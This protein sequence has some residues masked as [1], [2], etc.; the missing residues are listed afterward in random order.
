MEIFHIY[1]R[2]LG[3]RPIHVTIPKRYAYFWEI[4]S[5]VSKFHKIDSLDCIDPR[6]STFDL[7]KKFSKQIY[8][9]L[10]ILVRI[11]NIRQSIK[12]AKFL[13]DLNPEIKILIYGDIVELIPD[14]FKKYKFIDALITEGDWELSILS[15]ADF[16]ENKCKRPS[17]IRINGENKNFPGKYLCK[18]WELTDTSFAPIDYY[19]F[20]NGNKQLSLTVAKGCF[21]DCKFCLSTKTFG[22]K[23]RR[24]S[25]KK[26]IQYLKNNSSRFESFKFFAPSFTYDQ[27]WV[28]ALCKKIIREKI[29]ISWCATSRIDLLDDK[30]LVSLMAKAGCYKIS[31]GIETIN[32]SADFLKK[33]F[34]K[35]Q[36]ARVASYFNKNKITL[37]GL[38]MLGVPKQKKED[39][40]ELFKFM[41]ENNIK[42][43]PTSYSPIEELLQY[44]NLTISKIEKFDK[45]TF[46]K[47]GIKGLSRKNYFKLILDPYSFQEILNN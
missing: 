3:T 47:Y 33:N 18:N 30:K 36:I 21:F 20:L 12:I 9:I 34:K 44:R 31:V 37:K 23:E 26:I 38:V 2:Q 35:D 5:F 22:K 11:E 1:P 32:E 17:G 10:V 27:K 29:R 39:I 4:S 42:I 14:F 8:K 24:L 16:I 41:V 25:I 46:Y 19:N 7:S 28:T 13:K 40:L 43:R 15:Y 45:F 6:I